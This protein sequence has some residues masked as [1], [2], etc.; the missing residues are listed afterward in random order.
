MTPNPNS[1]TAVKGHSAQVGTRG[2]VAKVD[3]ARC[4]W[5]DEVAQHAVP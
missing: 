3:I 5:Y 4:K 2:L 1:P